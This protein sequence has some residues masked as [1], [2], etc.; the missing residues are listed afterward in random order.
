MPCPAPG[1]PTKKERVIAARTKDPNLSY[2]DLASRFDVGLRTVKTWLAPTGLGQQRTE[3]GRGK[4]DH[5]RIM[6]P[7]YPSQREGASHSAI[8]GTAVRAA[9]L[10]MKARHPAMNCHAASKELGVSTGAVARWWREAGMMAPADDAQSE[11]H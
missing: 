3:D 10:M 6:A 7:A 1:S 8:G 5:V 11:A 2:A 4:K 9:A